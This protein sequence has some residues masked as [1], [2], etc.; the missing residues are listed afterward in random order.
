V[1]YQQ[2]LQLTVGLD[3][4]LLFVCFFAILFLVVCV[5]CV[6]F[7]FFSTKS[8]DFAGKN[9]AEMIYVVSSVT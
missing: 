2:F 9:V 7:S 1:T 6:R 8:R 5:C 4:A 3:F